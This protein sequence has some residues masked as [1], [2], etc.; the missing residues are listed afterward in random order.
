VPETLPSDDGMVTVEMFELGD[1]LHPEFD[2]PVLK[3]TSDGSR[4]CTVNS[5]VRTCTLRT[6]NELNTLS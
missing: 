6:G 5:K 1:M 2:M 3:K 4:F